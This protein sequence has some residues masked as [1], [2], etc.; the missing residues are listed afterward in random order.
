MATKRQRE[1]RKARMSF[2][3][4]DPER[5]Q[6]EH[7]SG[8]ERTSIIL[9]ENMEMFKLKAGKNYRVDIIPYIAGSGNPH[10][11]EGKPYYERTYFRHPG[12]G[13]GEDAYVCLH[14]TFKEKCPVCEYR[15]KAASKGTLDKKS[16]KDLAPKER[17]LF[18]VFDHGEPDKGVQLWEISFHNFGKLLDVRVKTRDEDED[19]IKF[20]W[21]SDVKRKGCTLKLTVTEEQ[22]EERTF[23]KVTAI[24]FKPRKEPLSDEILEQAAC[25]DECLV[26]TPYDKLKAIFLQ[27]EEGDEDEDED[28]D[29]EPKKPP[30]KGKKPPVEEE[31]DLPELDDFEEEEDEE[32]EEEEE[33][34]LEPIPTQKAILKM[35]RDSL[36]EVVQDYQLDV[37]P[38]EYKRTAMLAKKVAE[39]AALYEESEEEDDLPELEEEED[40]FDEE[41]EIDEDEDFEEEDDF[42]EEPEE[43]EE[44]EDEELDDFE[45][46]DEIED[47][48]DEE[49]EEPA[50]KKRPVKKKAAV[51]KPAPAKKASQTGATKQPAK[52]GTKKTGKK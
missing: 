46:D 39:A 49:E 22:M 48:E 7:K 16:L 47:F 17:Q 45:E 51:K 5:R 23:P 28:F 43:M 40:E 25:L 32:A 21:F 50:P 13:S 9:P 29:D 41:A 33:G 34:E 19:Y 10:A 24:D 6:K 52:K 37:D 3:G 15:A 18:N 2:E 36:L 42:E 14:Q 1:E 12:L 30:K 4:V 26:H 31:D 38:D 35:D 27:Q 44:D 20:W 11:D 8:F